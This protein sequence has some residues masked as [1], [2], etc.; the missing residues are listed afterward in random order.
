MPRIN[1]NIYKLSTSDDKLNKPNTTIGSF[2][3]LAAVIPD[4]IK[5]S[6]RVL[7]VEGANSYMSSIQVI[8]VNQTNPTVNETP[9]KGLN[10]GAI[11]GGASGGLI[12]IAVAVT[13]TA[14]P[15]TIEVDTVAIPVVVTPV[16]ERLSIAT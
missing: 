2:V 4:T 6:R 3:K 11:I 8:N 7:S 5:S 15:T 14:L 12:L 13:V 16:T 9:E 1:S 10:L